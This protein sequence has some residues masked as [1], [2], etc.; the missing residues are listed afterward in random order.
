MSTMLMSRIFLPSAEQI[1][2]HY[3]SAQTLCAILESRKLRFTDINM[4]SDAHET[5]CGY[6]VFEEAA[7]RLI[8]RTDV[9]EAVPEM[10]IA[11]FDS[12][13]EIL[14]RIQLIA[15]PFVSCLSLAGD[16]LGQWRAYA[17][18]GRGFAMGFRAAPLLRLP[19]TVLSVQYERE[20]QVKEMMAALV[21][22]FQ[23]QNDEA[24]IAKGNFFEDCVLLGTYMVG[25]KESAFQHERE[26]RCLHAVNVIN[27]NGGMRFTDPGGQNDSGHSFEGVSIGF[28]VRDNH[29]C[30]FL[31][32]P[33][34]LSD[35][36]HPLA[37]IVLGPK[38]NSYAGNI[39]LYLGGLSYSEVAL[40]KSSV[41]YR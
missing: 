13:D 38:N 2:Y 1:I 27:D 19:V 40:R 32:L 18:D 22:I 6:T 34:W 33:F 20:L 21:A 10:S 16:D 25:F 35:S 30:A 11:F 4:L 24:D 36:A 41:P 3:C 28:Q 37:E 29:L 12:V 5:K 8:K 39:L 15:H 14:S 9:P 31:D 17:D 26:V 23:R 7:T